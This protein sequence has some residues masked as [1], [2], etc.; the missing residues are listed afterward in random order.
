M[1]EEKGRQFF[2]SVMYSRSLILMI[3]PMN[4][5]TSTSTFFTYAGG[6]VKQANVYGSFVCIVQIALRNLFHII[7]SYVTPFAKFCFFFFPYFVHVYP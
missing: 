4:Y 5:C 7:S 1:L 3:I 6:H 2:F